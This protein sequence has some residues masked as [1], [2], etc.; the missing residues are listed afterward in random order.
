MLLQSVILW[1]MATV[2]VVQGV[3]VMARPADRL[4]NTFFLLLT[5]FGAS[6]AVWIGIFLINDYGSLSQLATSIHYVSSI[7]L[8]WAF[9]QFA[10]AFVVENN[11]MRIAMALITIVPSITLAAVSIWYPS[12]LFSIDFLNKSVT[13][14]SDAGYSFAIYYVLYFI[15]TLAIFVYGTI[16]AKSRLL[17]N[18]TQLMTI[19]SLVSMAF[20][21]FFNLLLP[22]L[23]NWSLVWLGPLSAFIFLSIACYSIVRY[24]VFGKKLVVGRFFAYTIVLM[25]LTLL[26]AVFAVVI[27]SYIDGTPYVIAVSSVFIV[28]AIIFQ[29]LIGVIDRSINRFFANT[30]LSGKLFDSISRLAIDNIDIQKML[31]KITQT[32]TKS[33]KSSYAM[34]RMNVAN[35]EFTSHSQTRHI[36]DE[37]FD[38]I[39]G[40]FRKRKTGVIITEEVNNKERLYRVLESNSIS[41]VSILRDNETHHIVG[42]LIIGQEKPTLYSDKEITALSAICDVI[43]IAVRNSELSMLDKTKDEFMSIASHQLRTPLTSIQ[44][45]ASM[46]VDGDFGRVNDEQLHALNEI[47]ASSRR[48]TVLVDDLLNVS[49]LQ[50]GKF[51][52]AKTEVNLSELVKS[53]VDQVAILAA[54]HGVKVV[55]DDK[56]WDKIPSVTMDAAKIGEVMSNMIDNAIFYSRSGST[57]DVLLDYNKADETVGFRVRDHGIGVP[58]KDQEE[59]FTKFFR[60]SNSRTL[61]PDGTGIGLFLAK[62]VVT[63]HGGEIIFSSVEGQGSTFGFKLPLK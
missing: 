18:R 43:V 7:M 52:L 36:S 44:G 51:V 28:L 63:E 47:V 41:V 13:T 55:Y 34:I 31:D 54:S 21:G 61:R 24:R 3:I 5:I 10:F 56:K 60:A 33:S 27:N 15:L 45:Y 16:K 29:L 49:R 46:V 14:I 42:V 26:F 37:E 20:G 40:A 35:R 39:F 58:K 25:L 17:R 6:W 50:S 48:M 32:I 8:T 19:G 23:G 38:E 12:A 22:F 30:L 4:L 53:E 57:V 62:K 2:C 1:T 59:L 11:T 9:V